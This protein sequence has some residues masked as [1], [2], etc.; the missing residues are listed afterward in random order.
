MVSPV[1][2]LRRERREEKAS[3]EPHLAEERGEWAW[4]VEVAFLSLAAAA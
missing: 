1:V 2:V 4:R 3:S